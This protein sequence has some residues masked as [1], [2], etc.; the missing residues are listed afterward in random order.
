VKNLGL[1]S[2]SMTTNYAVRPVAAGMDR[3]NSTNQ[4]RVTTAY[5]F[6]SRWNFKTL[7]M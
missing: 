3:T 7:L 5:M 6:T 4:R 1:C 2:L